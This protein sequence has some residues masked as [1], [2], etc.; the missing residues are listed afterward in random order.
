MN[1]FKRVCFL[2]AF[3]A[4]LLI[5]FSHGN[6]DVD[7]VYIGEYCFSLDSRVEGTARRTLQLGILSYGG[8][9]YPVHGK[10]TVEGRAGL[11]PVHGAV[12][13]SGDD[14]VITLS[15]SNHVGDQTSFRIHA[16]IGEHRGE[17]QG[18]YT[19]LEHLATPY[20]ESQTA[21]YQVDSSFEFGYFTLIQCP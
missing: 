20:P 17:H 13:K 1:L 10:M 21:L 14:I 16:V 19:T 3:F 15:G 11:I 12:I 6:A 4:N 5:T 9:H 2:I 7:V 8:M 18:E